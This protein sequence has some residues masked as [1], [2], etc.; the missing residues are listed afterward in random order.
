[1]KPS[2][3]NRNLTPQVARKGGFALV[4]VLGILVLLV[5]LAVGFLVSAGTERASSSAFD[6]S[7]SA[8]QVGD[9]AVSLVQ[10]QINIATTQGSN[11]AW[12]SQPGMIRTFDA[13][14]TS[15]NSYK[16]YSASEMVATT[17]PVASGT[18]TDAPPA[19]WATYPGHWTDL[20]AP[21][22]INGTKTFPILDPPTN[23]L[24]GFSVTNAPGATTYQSAPMPV[25]WLYVLKDGALVAPTGSGAA[26]SVAE[27]TPENPIVGRVAFWTDDD[28]CKVNINTASEGTFWDVP[29]TDGTPERNLAN[30]QPVQREYQRYPGHPATTS[31]SAALPSPTPAPTDIFQIVPR[32]VGGGSNL[33]TVIATAALTPDSD[34]LYANVNELIFDPSRSTQAGLSRDAV[35]KA[36]F[37]IT[38][39]SRAPEV[40]LFNLPRIACWPLFRDLAP[41][42][43]TA[44]DKLIAFC[45]TVNDQPYYFQREDAFSPTNDINI[46]RNV[47]LY[48]YLQYLTGTSIPGFGG[49]FL[50]KYNDDRDQILTEIFDYV[51]STNL[52]DDNLEP[53]V[54]A[55]TRPFTPGRV[56]RS[57]NANYGMHIPYRGHG[58]VVPTVR[59]AN[60]TIGFGRFFTLSEF[61]IGFICNAVADNPTTTDVDE[62]YGSN[63]PVTNAALGGTALATEEKT[64]QAIIILELFS[65]SHGFTIMRPDIR[66]QIKGLDKLRVRDSDGNLHNLFPNLDNEVLVYNSPLDYLAGNRSMGGRSDWRYQFLTNNETADT[67]NHQW[68]PKGIP[69]RGS[70]PGDTGRPDMFPFVG[71]PVKIAAPVTGGAMTLTTEID[72]PTLPAVDPVLT[73]EIYAGTRANGKGDLVQSID[74]NL[75]VADFPIPNL[76]DRSD[77][78]YGN[79][80]IPM[81]NWWRYSSINGRLRTVLDNSTAD[82]ARVFIQNYDVIRTILPKHGD[83]RLVAGRREVPS[84]VF[85]PHRYYDDLNQRYAT[86]LGSGTPQ[87]DSFPYFDKGG[88]FIAAATYSNNIIPD[89]HAEATAA[90]RPELTG[91]YDTGVGKHS[92]GSYI[93]KPDEG[94]TLRSEAAGLIPYL[95][96]RQ[97]LQAPSGATFFS[98]NRQIPSPGMFG[99]LPTGIKAGNPWQTL[100]FRPQAGHPGSVTPPDH[101]ILD[102]FWMPVVEPY[103]ISD[104]FSTAGKINMN[105]QIL[106]FTYITRSTGLRAVMKSEKVTAIPTNQGSIYKWNGGDYRRDI[107]IT[108]TLAQ[109]ETK[110]NQGGI[111]KSAS[112]I[113]DLWI[114]PQG[115][116]AGQAYWD[117]NK[118]TGDNLRERIYTTLY[119]RLTTKSNTY[120]VYFRAQALKKAPGS[121]AG[122]WTEGRDIVLGEYRGSTTLERFINPE[123]DIPNYAADPD[124]IPNEETLDSFYKWRVIENKQ[125]AP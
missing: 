117:N 39:H 67:P 58:S 114:V 92:D 6:A 4:V 42:R 111:F 91:D 82:W 68:M 18:S 26:A 56:F 44:F 71:I 78:P 3:F 85:V 125:F 62:S 120:T 61:G 9:I 118:L 105:Y 33:G 5:V 52:F 90:E 103:A 109:F 16:L 74:I 98:P 30:Y 29:H 80:L 43:V 86:N 10:G 93:N 79:S 31:L 99:S 57:I 11:V 48:D 72:D 19:N 94:D 66:V 13:S 100:L 21:V 73:V 88:K 113:C 116:S 108:A 70:M 55:S 123:A 119:P 17:I 47:Q 89:I 35:E 81:Q 64:I 28:T 59:A 49:N 46:A 63:D 102:L 107:D 51:R 76:V 121:A 84:T 83:Y 110:F 8:R 25:R 122:T 15:L 41:N 36:K 65:P 24:A 45:S 101:L 60:D 95:S 1:M 27:E 32:V 54:L 23:T 104:R 115:G 7:V 87:T 75:P 106:P 37:F 12:A 53:G 40:N 14:G 97:D 96:N 22:E 50:A 38:A 77:I 20:N 124:E 69:A 2:L 34:R 112:E